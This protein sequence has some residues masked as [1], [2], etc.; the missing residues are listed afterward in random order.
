MEE[1]NDVDPE[2]DKQEIIVDALREQTKI[3]SNTVIT[4]LLPAATFAFWCY[5]LYIAIIILA[6]C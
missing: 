5:L 4:D 1:L 3:S 2:Y 6:D